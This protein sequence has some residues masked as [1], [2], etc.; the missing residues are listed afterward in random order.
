MSLVSLKK[1]IENS[2]IAPVYLC[3]GEDR[4]TLAEALKL[5]KQVFLADD[6]AG[7]NIEYFNG[8]EAD[9]REV[10]DIAN[11]CSFFARK[12]VL[13]D[14][15]PFFDSTEGSGNISESSDLLLDYINDPNP[16]T[17]LVLIANK[18][19]KGRRLFKEINKKGEI[20]E[21]IYP[22]DSAEWLKWVRNEVEARG[23]VIKAS[24]ASFLLEWSGH[25]TGILSQEL[26]KLVLYTE[27]R[28]EINIEDI[29]EVAVPL[30]ET[31]VFSMLDAIAISNTR[32][33]LQ[34][35][36]EVLSLEKYHLRVYT[37]IV[38]Q[39]RLLLAA[40][41]VRN[42]GGTAKHFREIAGLKPFEATKIFKQAVRFT[43]ERLALALED[44]LETEL[45]LKS[46]GG[47]PE[48]LLEIMVIRLC[49]R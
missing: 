13:V 19:N 49:Q 30:I 29:K 41:L 2:N 45:A 20:L 37:M 23:R 26:D 39:I 14:E 10:L 47:A 46:S 32:Q 31:Q 34:R 18:V 22:Q 36:A 11:T 3:Y 4:Y 5:L 48:F 33:A 16:M 7:S 12:L 43:P 35:L 6:P 1:A 17:C 8:K 40:K 21:F 25:N 9:W 27:G 38:R 15:I 24:T 28:K 44:C 42:S